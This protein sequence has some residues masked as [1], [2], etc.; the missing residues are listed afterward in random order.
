MWEI[1]EWDNDNKFLYIYKAGI[2]TKTELTTLTGNATLEVN[3]VIFNGIHF[4]SN[5][6]G[7]GWIR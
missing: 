2:L 1:S 6:G 5:D 7:Y 4:N 3:K